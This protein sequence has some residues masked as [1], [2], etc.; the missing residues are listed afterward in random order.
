[1]RAGRKAPERVAHP[2]E[3]VFDEHSQ[4]LVLGT[5]PSPKS[6]ETGFYYNHPQN[7]FWKVMAAL[8]DEPLPASNDEK[9]ALALRHG[10]ALWDVLA[11]C[12]IAGAADGTIAE[13]V[14]NDLGLILD[15]APIKAVFCTGAKAAELYRKHCEPVTG[16]LCVRLPST[17]PANAGTLLEQLVEA[18]RAIVPFAR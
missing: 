5:M 10:I 2:L 3:P 13:C 18:Y 9:R 8:F 11:E 17:S 4:V 7:R 6:R 14:P 16:R 12:S 1:M 15:Q